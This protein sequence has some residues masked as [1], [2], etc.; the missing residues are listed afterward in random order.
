[1]WDWHTS[2]SPV[3]RASR[4]QTLAI[5]LFVLTST[6]PSGDERLP[7]I[8][9][10]CQPPRVGSRLVG[11]CESTESPSKAGHLLFRV[12]AGGTQGPPAI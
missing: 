2:C 9:A 10:G 1:M 12:G 7:Q 5:A 6:S 11:F 8:V 3:I 4:F